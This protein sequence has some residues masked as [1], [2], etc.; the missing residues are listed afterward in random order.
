MEHVGPVSYAYVS[1]ILYLEYNGHLDFNDQ[2]N[3]GEGQTHSV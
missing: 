2:T 3:P 1:F